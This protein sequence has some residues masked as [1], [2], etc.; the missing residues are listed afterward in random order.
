MKVRLC[1][2]NEAGHLRDSPTELLFQCLS[3]FSS[4]LSLKTVFCEKEQCFF[5]ITQGEK[6]PLIFHSFVDGT[7]IDW[8]ISQALI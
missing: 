1:D 3:P 5:S 7:N 2:G 6:M 4:Q 8:V